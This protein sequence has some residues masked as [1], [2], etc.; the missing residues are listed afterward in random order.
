MT[1]GRSVITTNGP[2][3]NY[4]KIGRLDWI[5]KIKILKIEMK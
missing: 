3:F 5:E 4:S 2:T 1:T